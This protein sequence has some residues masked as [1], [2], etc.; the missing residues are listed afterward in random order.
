MNKKKESSFNESLLVNIKRFLYLTLIIT[1]FGIMY[2]SETEKILIAIISSIPIT[3][4]I[5]I[6]YLIE[7]DVANNKTKKKKEIPWKK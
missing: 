1:T 7:K 3:F 2:G 6:K 4:T 5:F